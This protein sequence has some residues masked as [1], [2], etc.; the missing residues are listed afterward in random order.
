LETTSSP[1][2]AN[3][4][5]IR[6]ILENPIVAKEIKGRMRGKQGFI[7]LTA[8]LALVSL[9]IVG[10]YYLSASDWNR[11]RI[12]PDDLQEFGKQV[13][14]AVALL[15]FLLIIIIGSALTSGAIS[16]ERERQTF[17]LLRVSLL[18]TLDLIL[19]KLGAAIAFLALLILAALPLQSLAF[20]IGGVGMAE[21]AVSLV[22]LAASALMFCALGVYFS[23]VAR[24]TVVATVMT[25]A[26]AIF[27]IILLAGLYLFLQSGDV[28]LSELSTEQQNLLIFFFWNLLSTSPFTAALVSEMMLE[29]EQILFMFYPPDF[30]YP[31]FSPW[32]L[33][34]VF[35]VTM[36]ALMIWLIAFY[37]NRYER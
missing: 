33:Y 8:Y 20:F 19:G 5:P 2:S 24:R 27:P 3:W 10:L 9:A 32:V 35:S 25:Y 23:C 7:L 6:R 11:G 16:S 36:T 17:D 14:G 26:S 15:E 21:L 37:I 1:K 34:V 31:V 29:E 30:P 18:S 22:M 4:N 12:Q 13:F 28:D